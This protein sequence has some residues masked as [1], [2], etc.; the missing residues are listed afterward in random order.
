M[1]ITYFGWVWGGQ[2]YLQILPETS[3]VD[4]VVETL[5]TSF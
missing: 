3:V 2:V 4:G 1:I 5:A